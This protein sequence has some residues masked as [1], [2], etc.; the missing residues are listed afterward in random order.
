MH[1]SLKLA[2]L[3]WNPVESSWLENHSVRGNAADEPCDCDAPL[4]SIDTAPSSD[5]MWHGALAVS[6]PRDSSDYLGRIVYKV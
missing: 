6:S 5:E 1:K 4:R 3:G 2:A